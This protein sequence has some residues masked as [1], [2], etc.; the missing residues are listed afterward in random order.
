MS[1][2]NQSESELISP[3][4]NEQEKNSESAK[5]LIAD[6]GV[7]G[8]RKRRKGFWKKLCCARSDT[9]DE[10]INMNVPVEHLNRNLQIVINCRKTRINVNMHP[11]NENDARIFR[12]VNATKL[13]E[14]LSEIKGGH[15]GSSS[16]IFSTPF[17][18]PESLVQG[19]TEIS[20]FSSTLGIR[21]GTL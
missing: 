8:T 17:P 10:V 9:D 7:V 2:F 5:E 11:Q 18:D 15:R 1:N 6:I 16:T 21:H 3:E 14:V 12:S 13:K 4:D 20:K 19:N